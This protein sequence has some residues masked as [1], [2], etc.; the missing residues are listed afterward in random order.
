MRGSAE[1]ETQEEGTAGQGSEQQQLFADSIW[2]VVREAAD[3]VRERLPHEIRAA[4]EE[5]EVLA[6]M[7][8]LV[9]A[10]ASV[11][12]AEAEAESASDVAGYQRLL[13]LLY[14]EVVHGWA[15]RPQAPPKA[16]MLRMLSAFQR[17]RQLVSPPAPAQPSLLWS[18][19]QDA[20]L[21]VE[22]AH[23][24]R[25]PLTSI[26]FLTESLR[27][28]QGGSVNE[29]QRRQ[30]G[31]IYSA[32]LSLVS[33]ASDVIDLAKG[34]TRLLD[35]RPSPFSI[36]E[37]IESTYDILKPVVEEKQL[38][39]LTIRPEVDQRLGH[40]VA[41]SRVLLNLTANALRYTDSG[42]VEIAARETGCS[43][44][45]FSVRDT[46]PGMDE[47]AVKQLFEPM[48]RNPSNQRF[49]FSGSGLGLAIC[50]RLVAVMGAE[51]QYESA[52]GVGTRF[53][54]EVE[55]PPVPVP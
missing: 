39:L 41:L 37:V 33:M 45:E 8:L 36:A 12:G 17:V 21:V 52:P 10:L 18:V 9:N 14:A 24:L 20:E 23:D 32:A 55:V 26:I 49:G 28:E 46:G 51:L 2:T 31:I 5:T 27:R 50:R 7:D 44:I 6:R 16:Q 35:Q 38:E 40:P 47:E 1:S 53:Y 15:R 13:D 4:R 30:L 42:V 3:R 25:S 43:T 22:L 34:G 54:F 29:L 48:R 19:P 11:D